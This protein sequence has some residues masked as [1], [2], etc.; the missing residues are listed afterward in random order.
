M[1]GSQRG[2]CTRSP[3]RCSPSAAAR[4]AESPSADFQTRRGQTFTH[5]V[6]SLPRLGGML[7]RRAASGEHVV[8]AGKHAYPRLRRVKACHPAVARGGGRRDHTKTGIVGRATPH[9]GE[10]SAHRARP[11]M[12]RIGTSWAVLGH[13][14]SLWGMRYALELGCN[15]FANRL[16]TNDL[17]QPGRKASSNP[18]VRVDWL[19]N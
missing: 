17:R 3:G 7:S 2:A 4:R 11:K 8:H 16:H 14:R 12:A 13:N 10:R 18:S 6:P 1:G 19:E 5:S 9:F 15:H